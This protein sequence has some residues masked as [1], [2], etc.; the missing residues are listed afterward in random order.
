MVKGLRKAEKLS[1]RQTRCIERELLFH[2]KSTGLARQALR[3]NDTAI[4][5]S[6][7]QGILTPVRQK[8]VLGKR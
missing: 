5:R 7:L 6:A 1:A 8:C 3:G 2:L 4:A